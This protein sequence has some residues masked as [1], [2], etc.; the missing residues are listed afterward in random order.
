MRLAWFTPLAP[1]R[2]GIASYSAEIL[3]LLAAAHTIDVFVDEPVFA[4]ARARE[5]GGGRGPVLRGPRYGVADRALGATI[6]SAHDFVPLNTVRPYDLVVYQMGNA[7][8]H[9]YMWPYALRYPG[10]LVLH[11][12]L[13]HHARAM[14]LLGRGRVADYRAEFVWH[15]PDR[16]ANLAEFAVAGLSGALHYLMPM[17]HGIVESSR[18]VAVHDPWTAAELRQDHEGTVVEPI[19]MGVPRFPGASAHAPP[20]GDQRPVT[21][22]AFGLVTPEKRIPQILRALAEVSR[23]TPD[24]RLLL[25]GD[26]A[27]HFDAMAAAEALGVAGRITLT[28][29]VGDEALAEHLAGI[30]VAIC[31]RWPT[32]RETSASWLRCLAA[33]KPTITNDLTHLVD[34]PSLDP[35]SWIVLHAAR[36]AA[37]G[38]GSTISRRPVC[39]SIDILDEDH[40]LRLAMQRL[41]VDAEL[42][43]QLGRSAEDY[44][45][46]HHTLA[47]MAEDYERV[48][49][50]AAARPPPAPPGE[51]PIHVDA[52]H[53]WRLG[54][55][56]AEI[57]VAGDPFGEGVT[58]ESSLAQARSAN[59]ETT[60]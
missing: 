17:R 34:V 4:S 29:F 46:A 11:D 41:A 1:V 56:L 53:R 59:R 9:D 25:V 28:G 36:D 10:L 58:R 47:H 14:A 55:L 54:E 20:P 60:D 8:C 30:D 22:A 18:A 52:D 13:L 49:Q 27:S 19:R 42:R 40:S 23:M 26:R 45:R 38:E 48:L 21:F 6:L 12:T 39:V 15:H 50:L 32:T 44:W 35:R 3:P 24:V 33:A 37:F 51:R 43:A 31:L 16:R 5:A 7:A 57:G 2:S